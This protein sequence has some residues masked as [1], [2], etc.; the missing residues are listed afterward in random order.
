MQDL[1]VVQVFSRQDEAG[2]RMSAI[3]QSAKR[4]CRCGIEREDAG[5]AE[6]S[7][8]L[9]H[10][11]SRGAVGLKEKIIVVDSTPGQAF[12]LACVTSSDDHHVQVVTQANGMPR[13]LLLLHEVSLRISPVCRG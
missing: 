8:R 5:S 4:V 12:V 13:S 10:L 11:I 6:I 7:E 3:Y 2:K 9:G 1:E